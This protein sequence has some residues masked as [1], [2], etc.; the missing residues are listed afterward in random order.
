MAG[1][2]PRPHQI[3]TCFGRF[4]RLHER[5]AGFAPAVGPGDAGCCYPVG[6]GCHPAAGWLGPHDAAV[7]AGDHPVEDSRLAAFVV[8][9]GHPVD[10]S[11]GV[12]RGDWSA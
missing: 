3:V 4:G 11:F 8:G 7:W 1:A 2:I 9:P 5:A 12:W 10:R 6:V